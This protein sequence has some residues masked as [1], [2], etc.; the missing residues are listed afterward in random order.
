V[1]VVVSRGSVPTG[2]GR[3]QRVVL[4]RAG[5]HLLVGEKLRAGTKAAEAVLKHPGRYRRVRDTL[6]IKEVRLTR[7]SEERRFVL[8]GDPDQAE[9]DRAKRH[10]LLERFE[11]GL[12]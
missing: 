4:Q 11:A 1:P 7:G 3:S 5:G 6:E 2:Y 12:D 9:R 10:A 8:V